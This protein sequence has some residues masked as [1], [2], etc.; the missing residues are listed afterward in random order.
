MESVPRWVPRMCEADALQTTTPLC[1]RN[2][3]GHYSMWTWGSCT[4]L[5]AA[6][7][8]FTNVTWAKMGMF[9][10]QLPN[11]KHVLVLCFKMYNYNWNTKKKHLSYFFEKKKVGG[12]CY[13]NGKTINDTKNKSLCLY[14]FIKCI[15]L[16]QQRAGV[17][18]GWPTSQRALTQKHINQSIVRCP[19]TPPKNKKKISVHYPW[20]TVL[21]FLLNLDFF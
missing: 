5:N 11:K 12:V 2:H 4:K 9:A 13:T 6:A 18:R 21:G 3:N 16:L 17:G 1:C 7:G 8:T 19:P 20:Q 10:S 15:Y 14:L